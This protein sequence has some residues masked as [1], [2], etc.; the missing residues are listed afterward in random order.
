MKF[1]VYNRINEDDNQ[2]ED[3][4]NDQNTDVTNSSTNN[5]MLDMQNS[6]LSKLM[7]DRVKRK[8]DYQAELKK[9][10]DGMIILQKNISDLESVTPENDE[11]ARINKQNIM[12]FNKLMAD[13]L[14][15]KLRLKQVYRQDINKI[16]QMILALEI[17]IADQGG[18]VD[19]N[20]IEESANIRFSKKL[21]ESVLNKT[22]EMFASI[23][24][25]F[26]DM[27]NLSYRPDNT[28]CRT[29]AKNIIAFT[30]KLGSTLD[31]KEDM[32]RQFVRSLLN[33]SHISLGNNEKT[34]FIDK[35]CD[36]L[37]E[38]TLFMWIFN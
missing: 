31:D 21:Y 38:N 33:S 8:T 16:D 10:N 35:L 18:R 2:A 9:V 27:D 11:Q 25:A 24:M 6:Q 13:K 5:S 3:N 29:F 15:V 26:D 28:K 17:A 34:K 23:C 36:V 14:Q 32:F 20:S 19:P 37:R 22:D 30:N 1:N 4:T 12:R 7:N